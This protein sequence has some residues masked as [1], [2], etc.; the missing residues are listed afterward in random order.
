ML[1]FFNT[2][3]N[4]Y[5]IGIKENKKEEEV[6]T[7]SD[8]KEDLK[9]SFEDVMS[10]LSSRGDYKEQ[11]YKLEEKLNN[12]KEV[13]KSVYKKIDSLKELGFVNTPSVSTVSKELDSSIE[14]IKQ[15]KMDLESKVFHL[16]SLECSKKQSCDSV[17]FTPCY[18][19][20]IM[21]FVCN[22]NLIL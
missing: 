3:D 8:I 17:I 12:F 11:V 22:T 19:D 20:S 7:S 21:I 10:E 18:C 5:A 1:G 13:N 4:A 6:I 14:D 16:N 2:D 9:T 15:E